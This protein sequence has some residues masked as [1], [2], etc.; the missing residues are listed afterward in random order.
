MKV[1]VTEILE[2]SSILLTQKYFKLQQIFESKYGKDTIILMEIGTF[3]E[4]YEVNNKEEQIGKAKEIAELLNIQLTRKNKSILENSQSNPLMAGVPAISFEKHINRIIQEQKYTIAIIKQVG[5]PPNV[6]RILEAIISPGTN[7]D[8]AISSDENNITSIVVDQ[9]RGNYLIGYSAIDVTTGKCFY[10]EV[11]G[12]SEDPSFALDEVYNYMN[13]HKTSEVIVTFLDKSI[14]QS[15]VIEYLELSFKT[16]HISNIK[17]KINYQNELFKNVFEIE[18]LL[19]PIEH[20]N[21]ERFAL[22]SESLAILI[23]FVIGHDS[24][25][26]Q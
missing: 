8:F 25:I 26:I 16:F 12:T 20:L 9:I 3:F 5:V 22:A 4:V 14:N 13:M 6:K 19:T 11:F 2:D 15:E 7:F 17:P 10:N 1:Q 23:D 18:S 24:N 21:M